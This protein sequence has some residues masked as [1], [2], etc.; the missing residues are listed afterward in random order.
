MTYESPRNPDGKTHLDITPENLA[1]LESSEPILTKDDVV[2][3][4][5]AAYKEHHTSE[6]ASEMTKNYLA[7]LTEEEQAEIEEAVENSF[8]SYDDLVLSYFR[9]AVKGVAKKKETSATM[10]RNWNN[11]SDEE[12]KNRV[13]QQ[14][15]TRKKN[16]DIAIQAKITEA[17]AGGRT[18]TAAEAKDEI[19]AEKKAAREAN[20]A[21]A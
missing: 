17:K 3:R 18:I 9:F 8:A 20:K 5:I 2:N 10:S 16:E 1:I 21:T 11:L 12:Q 19:K 4:A 15:A 7:Q 6:P 14:Q 13:A